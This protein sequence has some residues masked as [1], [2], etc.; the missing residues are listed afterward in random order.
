MHP[1]YTKPW[2]VG[3]RVNPA[4]DRPAF[5]FIQYGEDLLPL[6]RNNR[7]LTCVSTSGISAI[8]R[9]AHIENM[10]NVT[11]LEVDVIYDIAA[12]LDIVSNRTSDTNAD[13]VNC[14]NFLLDCVKVAGAELLAE[15]RAPLFSLADCGTFT[16]ELSEWLDA[17][18]ENRLRARHAI[19]WCLGCLFVNLD[20]VE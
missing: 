4:L 6:C 14:L 3:L 2:V 16:K 19:I 1:D 18:P 5:F 7:V 15:D 20:I 17:Q 8:L 9:A 12:V 13:V 11:A 10:T